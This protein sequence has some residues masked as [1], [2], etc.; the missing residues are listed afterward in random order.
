MQSVRR[1]PIDWRERGPAGGTRPRAIVVPDFPAPAGLPFEFAALLPNHAFNRQLTEALIDRPPWAQQADIAACFMA[2]PFLNP[3]SFAAVLRAKGFGRICN[4]PTIA[5]LG[6]AL[7][8]MSGDVNL[9][10]ARERERLADFARLGFEVF[11]VITDWH[12]WQMLAGIVPAGIIVARSFEAGQT[13]DDLIGLAR[14]VATET[15]GRCPVLMLTGERFARVEAPVAGA[16]H[17]GSNRP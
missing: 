13:G 14:S 11:P 17:Y 1:W 15:D 12:G 6:R 9:G 5:Q 10:P 3:A 16:I 8:G 4:L 2:D 7:T